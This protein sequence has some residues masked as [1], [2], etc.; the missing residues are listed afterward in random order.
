MRR[1]V[2]WQARIGRRIINVLRHADKGCPM[3]GPLNG[4]KSVGQGFFNVGRILNFSTVIGN[5]RH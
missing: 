5:W 3:L 1:L 4:R 2:N